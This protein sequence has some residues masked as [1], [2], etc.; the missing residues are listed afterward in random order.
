MDGRKIGWC[1][2]AGSAKA[3]GPYP[4]PYARWGSR[5]LVGQQSRPWVRRLQWLV[6]VDAHGQNTHNKT[7]L[8]ASAISRSRIVHC[9]ASP[10]NLPTLSATDRPLR[11]H[12][13]PCPSTRQGSTC[14]AF[15][16]A[17]SECS[18]S[19]ASVRCRWRGSTNSDASMPSA[20][21]TPVLLHTSRTKRENADATDGA[22][23]GRLIKWVYSTRG[24]DNCS[25][26]ACNSRAR[27]W[28][29]ARTLQTGSRG[30]PTVGTNA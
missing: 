20:P 15:S 23:S 28:N 11:S 2:S 30:R 7:L 8:I 6:V 17:A 3:Y 18:L 27:A 16:R 12:P 22:V 25:R 21:M 13:S 24:E 1:A 5:L 4:T 26:T 9:S 19:I 29:T 10:A 14:T